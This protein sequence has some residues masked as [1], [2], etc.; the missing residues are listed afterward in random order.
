MIKFEKGKTYTTYDMGDYYVEGRTAKRL[1]LIDQFG[2]TRHVGIL[3]DEEKEWARPD[4]RY[5]MCPVIKADR[6]K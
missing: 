5:S 6:S 1:K 2:E 4:G 3:S